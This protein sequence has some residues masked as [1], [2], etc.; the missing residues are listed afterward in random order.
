MRKEGWRQAGEGLLG[1]WGPFD[2]KAEPGHFS[3]STGRAVTVNGVSI[4]PPKVYTGPGLSLRHT[5][6]FLLL[7]T[8]LGLS[9]L[10]D[11]GQTPALHPL[12]RARLSTMRPTPPT[13]FPFRK[14]GGSSQIMFLKLCFSSM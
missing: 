13:L 7:T 6:L 3:P 10:W 5:G 1:I 9:L 2:S 12:T 8:R 4:T 11:G 14:R